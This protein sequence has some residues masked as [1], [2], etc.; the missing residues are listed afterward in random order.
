KRFVE[1]LSSQQGNT[2]FKKY[3]WTK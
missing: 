1:F 3:G 2:I